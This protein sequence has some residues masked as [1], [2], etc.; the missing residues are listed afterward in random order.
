M[1][2]LGVVK[3]SLIF[4][5]VALCWVFG[6]LAAT[7][8]ALAYVGYADSPGPGWFGYVLAASFAVSAGLFYSAAGHLERTSLVSPV[9]HLAPLALLLLVFAC[10][11]F[12]A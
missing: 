3:K 12:A 8:L 6:V 5:E 1:A 4:A 11:R 10:G 7:G 2:D 9:P